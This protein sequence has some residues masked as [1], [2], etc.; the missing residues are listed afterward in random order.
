MKSYQQ[1]ATGSVGQMIYLIFIT[2][3][4]EVEVDSVWSD[5]QIA[6]QTAKDLQ[7]ELRR[8]CAAIVSL[9]AW[10]VNNRNGGR[11]IPLA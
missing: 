8:S 3:G 4:D 11:E 2:A 7:E 10:P 9:S 6:I 1:E 5:Q